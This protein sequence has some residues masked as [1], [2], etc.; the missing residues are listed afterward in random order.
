[1]GKNML[2]IHHDSLS[3]WAKD[4]S[5]FPSPA[6][7]WW[8]HRLCLKLQ[9]GKTTGILLEGHA[10]FF[11]VWT[12]HHGYGFGD[13]EGATKNHPQENKMW[14]AFGISSARLTWQMDLEAVY[15]L[16]MSKNRPHKNT[17]PGQI[18]MKYAESLMLMMTWFKRRYQQYA[19][20]LHMTTIIL[21]KVTMVCP[22]VLCV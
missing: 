16:T 22:T 15:R 5:G 2:S 12:Y 10:F 18:E 9:R 6:R 14:S 19:V 11:C 4:C 20:M 1:M 7:Y 8:D 17:K 3:P 21:M 13:L